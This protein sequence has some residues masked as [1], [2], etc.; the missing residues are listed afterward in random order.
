[1]KKL[2]YILLLSSLLFSSEKIEQNVLDF[3]R[4][5]LGFKADEDGNLNP[6]V[7]IPVKWSDSYYSAVGYEVT[8]IVEHYSVDFN[9]PNKF[10]I[11]A[12]SKYVWID[13]IGSKVIFEN[14]YFSYSFTLGYRE[15]D[16]MQYGYLHETDLTTNE[17][18]TF[19]T[20]RI[21]SLKTSGTGFYL[22]YTY[23]NLLDIISFRIA[24][25]IY[26]YSQLTFKEETAFM[27]TIP[28]VAQ[29]KSEQN[30][31]IRYDINLDVVFNIIDSL[32]IGINAKYDYL[33]Y[34]YYVLMPAMNGENLTFQSVKYQN[35]TT[36]Q[37]FGIRMIF[38][39]HSFAGIK[40][41]I[42]FEYS[43]SSTDSIY[44][45]SKSVSN[46]DTKN[47]TFGIEKKF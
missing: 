21:S 42:G 17:K 28:D 5:E 33:P 37:S 26:P 47:Y 27:P 43:S 24:S 8:S 18:T 1:M 39:K 4:F 14:S 35:N 10:V 20:N 6:K 2:I 16:M 29:V 44:P 34:K 11:A 30:Q 31:D 25:H 19:A 40:P 32:D 13:I 38:S 22:D 15:I 23:K 7:T 45:D 12:D 41:T 9:T 3:D 46:L 36:T